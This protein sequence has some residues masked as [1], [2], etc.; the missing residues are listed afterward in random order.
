MNYEDGN[1]E[2]GWNS[3]LA[4]GG[5]ILPTLISPNSMAWWRWLG[6]KAVTV[7][8]SCLLVHETYNYCFRTNDK[9]REQLCCRGWAVVCDD[10]YQAL[11]RYRLLAGGKYRP[12]TENNATAGL[13]RT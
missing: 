5:T 9:R 1:N 3:P 2:R 11:S 6:R 10:T 13:I 4:I 12:Y 8:D 7:G